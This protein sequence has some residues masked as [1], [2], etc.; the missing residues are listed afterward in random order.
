MHLHRGQRLAVRGDLHPRLRRSRRAGLVSAEPAPG[1]PP[2]HEIRVS[3]CL[4]DGC[5]EI[6]LRCV[7]GDSWNVEPGH[8]IAEL[9]GLG[10]QHVA[11]QAAGH[12]RLGSVSPASTER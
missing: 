5:G 8:T 7:C 2:K 6:I 3:A 10:A 1:G 11:A 12:P 4:D 9:D